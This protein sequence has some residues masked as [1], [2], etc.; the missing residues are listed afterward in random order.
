MDQAA[1]IKELEEEVLALKIQL[2]DTSS[3]CNYLRFVI[4]EIRDQGF[5]RS[6]PY[7]KTTSTEIEYDRKI[8]AMA[9]YISKREKF[10][11]S[12]KR[13]KKTDL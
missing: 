5:K 2:Q 9:N 12:P 7:S 6:G 8:S 3:F 10:L 4:N 1:R 13:G 11:M